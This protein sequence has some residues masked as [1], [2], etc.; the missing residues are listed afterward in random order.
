GAEAKLSLRQIVMTMLADPL[1]HIPPKEALAVKSHSILMA[2]A[3]FLI[4]ICQLQA[5]S[6]YTRLTPAT[7]KKQSRTFTITVDRF[8]DEKKGEYLRFNVNVKAKPGEAPLSPFLS[9]DLEVFD[10]DAVVS[11]ALLQGNYHDGEIRY[12]FLVAAKYAA[13]SK[14]TFGEI[15]TARNGERLDAANHYWFYLKDFVERPAPQ[16]KPKLEADSG[17]KPGA[18]IGI[19]I[20]SLPGHTDRLTSIAYSPD[21]TSIATASW[22]G[23]ARI[24]DPK[25]GKEVRRLDVPA[26]RDNNPA[27][28]FQ[29][30]F[31]SDNEFIVTAQQAAPNGIGV[32]VWKRSTGEKVHEFQNNCIVAL[33]PDGKQIAC[34]EREVNTGVIRLYEF[35]AGKLVREMRGQVPG[36]ASLTFSPDGKTLFSEGRINRPMRVEA[37]AQRL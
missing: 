4:F 36:I 31:S 28:L 37:E 29:I 33:A 20:R 22:D 17:A 9:T 14:F 27:R 10:G 19:P 3:C 2:L 23:T 6:T 30:L 11:S 12:S 16:E 21:G 1:T 32:I 35:P 18:D 13:K 25:T 34:G 15:L 5:T 7:V 26:T 8:K 24:W